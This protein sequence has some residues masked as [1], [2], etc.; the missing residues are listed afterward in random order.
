[1][2]DRERGRKEAEE[3]YKEAQTDHVTEIV[4]EERKRR[5]RRIRPWYLQVDGDECRTIT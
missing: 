3:Y 5:S 1:M 4:I 2:E